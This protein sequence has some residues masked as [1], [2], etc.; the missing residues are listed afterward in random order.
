MIHLY[1]SIPKSVI[2]YLYQ[3]TKDETYLNIC[4]SI[5]EFFMNDDELK[6]IDRIKIEYVAKGKYKIQNLLLKITKTLVK[7][8]TKNCSTIGL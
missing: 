1:S 2:Y 7:M 5:C 6:K 4:H 3:V 8:R